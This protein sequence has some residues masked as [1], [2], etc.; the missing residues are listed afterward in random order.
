MTDKFLFDDLT[1]EQLMEIGIASHMNPFHYDSGTNTR[2]NPMEFHLAQAFGPCCSCAANI[3]RVKAG[4]PIIYVWSLR[5]TWDKD[6]NKMQYISRQPDG[7]W[8]EV[9]KYY[10][11]F[12]E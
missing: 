11:K 12:K 6:T 4:E 10:Q 7:S 1:H 2:T 3:A 8:V 9:D 5:V